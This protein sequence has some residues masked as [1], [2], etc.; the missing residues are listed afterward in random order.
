MPL[1]FPPATKA[2]AWK[3]WTMARSEKELCKSFLVTS[4]GF[5][6]HGYVGARLG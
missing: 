2:A 6:I 5:A 4:M 3:S 1:H